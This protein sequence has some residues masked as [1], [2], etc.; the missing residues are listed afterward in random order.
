MMGSNLSAYHVFTK[1]RVGERYL[2]LSVFL[3]PLEKL[4]R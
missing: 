1:D 4:K 3:S 2:T